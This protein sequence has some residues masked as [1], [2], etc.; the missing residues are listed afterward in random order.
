MIFIFLLNFICSLVFACRLATQ[1]IT[2]IVE[3][4]ADTTE[5]YLLF[6]NQTEDDI[7]LRAELEALVAKNKLKLWYTVDRPPTQW[8]YRY[9]HVCC[10]C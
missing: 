6:A 10:C 7:L 9:A 4:P 3:N 1:L 5:L 2:D 8:A